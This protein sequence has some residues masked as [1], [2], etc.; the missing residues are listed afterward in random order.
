MKLHRIFRDWG[1]TLGLLGIV[2]QFCCD[3]AARAESVRHL[4]PYFQGVWLLAG[5]GFSYWMLQQG[6]FLRRSEA[7][8]LWKKSWPVC[9]LSGTFGLV[10]SVAGLFYVT[11][12]FAKH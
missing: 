4:L 9:L 6:L 7:G 12:L 11:G 1:W 2:V 10:V 3:L 8:S 5:A